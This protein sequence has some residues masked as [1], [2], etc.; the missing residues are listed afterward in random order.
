MSKSDPPRTEDPAAHQVTIVAPVGGISISHVGEIGGSTP[1]IPPASSPSPSQTFTEQSHPMFGARYQILS[2][3]GAG[4]MGTVYMAKDLELD[5]VV[6]LKVLRRE[7]VSTPG[8]LEMFRREVKLARLVTHPNV[9]RTFD[10]GEADGQRYLT[11]EFIEG[12]SLAR[13]LE[14][15]GPPPIA[16]AI[17]ILTALCDGLQAAHTVGVVHRDLKPENVLVGKQGRIVITDFG[18]A[19]PIESG[20]S[21]VTMG[22]TVGTPAYMSPEQVEAR[23]DVDHRADIFSLGVLMYELLSGS[24][25]FVGDSPLAVA[26]ARLI[27]PAPDIRTVRPDV[28]TLLA[29]LVMKCIERDRD[30]RIGSAAE[31]AKRLASI[32]TPMAPAPV[33]AAPAVAPSSTKAVAVLL[34][35]HGSHP[36]DVLLADGLLDD[37]I[38]G[39]S[40]TNGLRVRPRGR[41]ANVAADAD[42]TE[43]A[44]QLGVDVVVD[45]TVRRSGEQIRVS[46]RLATSDGFQIWARRF[47]KPA[48]ELFA[49]SDA[50][51]QAVSEALTVERTVP[52][53]HAAASAVAIE[54]YLRARA[55]SRKVFVAG[56]QGAAELYEQ[57]L[58]HAPD[59]PMILGGYAH[60]QTRAWFFGQPDAQGRA[61]DAANR[62]ITLA[63]QLP[64][65]RYALALLHAHSGKPAEALRL[66]K[67][68]AAQGSVPAH[69]TLA[70]L[71][72]EMGL[73]DE[74]RAIVERV[75]KIDPESA[76]GFFEIARAHAVKGEW[77]Q[78][79][80]LIERLHARSTVFRPE[81]SAAAIRFLMWRGNLDLAR[82]RL[83]QRG[84]VAVG[85][86]SSATLNLI[87]SG[88]G[89]KASLAP[90]FL[91]STEGGSLRRRALVH[92]IEAETAC[93][94]GDPAW[95]LD[96]LQRAVDAWLIDLIW[97]RL[98]PAIQPMRELAGFAPLASAVE[99][100]VAELSRVYRDTD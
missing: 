15:S 33:H 42:P 11:M 21:T 13:Q 8:A 89:T 48:A 83:E 72:S 10:I 86:I 43:I 49:L 71:L 36:D 69:E 58:R 30:Q 24:L 40:M 20:S 19:R 67:P 92:Q 87:L 1:S 4:G 26:A 44:R 98:C 61:R 32:T 82:E 38:D 45:G 39:L 94:L 31:V 7:V 73:L 47:D 75:L 12:V 41:V 56:I 97:L 84:G 27:R 80:A 5:E 29:D 34:F 64:E 95:G 25:P 63:P 9:A 88:E 65:A 77:A 81:V 37:L 2:L 59:D 46:A 91:E 62:A 78:C 96:A 51:A 93:S 54:L 79:D 14:A 57:A 68:L 85:P 23:R 50:I 52:D 70:T 74:S 53:R 76:F 100:R 6:A 3:L 90:K 66:L 28:P 18:V 16:R 99:Q 17:E 55:E 22:L 35:K 60:I